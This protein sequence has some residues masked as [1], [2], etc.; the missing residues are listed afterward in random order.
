M[1]HF[2]LIVYTIYVIIQLFTEGDEH[3]AMG[4]VG[5][6][7]FNEAKKTMTNKEFK[8]FVKQNAVKMQNAEREA[9]E[10]YRKNRK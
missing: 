6:E 3:R 7:K 1:I 5:P 2:I 9:A 8:K 10:Y 4:W